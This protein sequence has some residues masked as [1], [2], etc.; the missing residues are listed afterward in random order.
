MRPID[1]EFRLPV[2]VSERNLNGYEPRIG[3]D[4]EGVLWVQGRR[5]GADQALK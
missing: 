2:Y 3:E 4:V 1:N 5:I